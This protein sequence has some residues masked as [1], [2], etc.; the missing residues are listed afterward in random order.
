ME[1]S[2]GV[3][4]YSVYAFFFAVDSWQLQRTHQPTHIV[5][6]CCVCVCFQELE[7]ATNATACIESLIGYNKKVGQ[8]EAAMGI[9]TYAQNNLGSEVAVNKTWLSKLG[10]WE[11]R[12]QGL[13]CFGS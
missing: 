13:G 10:K 2:Y 5:C 8:P 1:L 4:F 9:L 12:E 7:F 3:Q 6:L 11:V